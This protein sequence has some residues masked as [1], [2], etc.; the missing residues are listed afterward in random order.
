VPIYLIFSIAMNQSVMAFVI[1]FTDIGPKLKSKIPMT[2]TSY[3][4]FMPP[5]HKLLLILIK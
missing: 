3:E 2:E 5:G 4:K 1:F